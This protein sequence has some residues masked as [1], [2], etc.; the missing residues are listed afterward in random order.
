LPDHHAQRPQR[1]AA[2]L[3]AAVG[4]GGVITKLATLSHSIVRS[5]L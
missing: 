5:C 3:A 2:R 4:C 1:A